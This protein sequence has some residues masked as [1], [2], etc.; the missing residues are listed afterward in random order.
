MKS[1]LLFTL[2]FIL[3][4]YDSKTDFYFGTWE[5]NEKNGASTLTISKDLKLT[6]DFMGNRMDDFSDFKAI[7]ISPNK[8]DILA[9]HDK[10]CEKFTLEKLSENQCL[11]CNYKC[12]INE[13]M[14]DEVFIARK[15][16]HPIEPIQKP[17][18]EVIILPPNYEGD[19][20]I[21][22]Q[23]LDEN[24]SREIKITDKGIGINKGEPDL[25]QLYNANRSFRFDN[26]EKIIPIANPKDYKQSSKRFDN[27]FNDGDV[28]II[29]KG[30]N[31]S[32]RNDWNKEHNQSI[33]D[34]LNI[35]Y[36]T[37]R[38]IKK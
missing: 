8:F 27:L 15:D 30:F 11:A 35:E 17:N 36:F 21:V 5:L 34:N 32:G 28:I 29:Q 26:Q 22:Y 23:Y 7:M 12:Y 13:N 33:K 19:F 24:Q 20:F 18:E 38:R 31:Q 3:S 2:L 16:Q 4:S 14:I 6:L 9:G 25:K 1:I 37:I 10:N